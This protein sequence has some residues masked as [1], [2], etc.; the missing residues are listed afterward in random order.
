LSAAPAV[1]HKS[2]NAWRF[3]CP[4][5]QSALDA[6]GETRIVCAKCATVY[7]RKNGI[8]SLL[9]PERRQ[10]FSRFLAEYTH[11][12]IAEGRGSQPA[13]YYTRLPECD[14]SHPMAWQ[15]RIRRCTVKAFDRHVA[16]MLARGSKI[17]D[18]GAGYGWFSNHL[19]RLGY[20]P[21]AIDLSVDAEDGLGAARHYAPEWPLVQAEF[22]HLPFEPAS[23]DVVV[24]NASLHY[25]TDY[26]RTITEALRVLSSGGR[27]VVLE[28]PIYKRDESGRRMAAERHA[29]FE[30]RYGTRSESVPSIEYLTWDMLDGLGSELGLTWQIIRPWYGVKR[31]LRPWMARLRKRREPSRFAILVATRKEP[32]GR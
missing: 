11:V 5:C 28:S 13:S 23:L 25:S 1:L 16:P 2:A 29:H 14:D 24:Y 27:I 22:D 8:L 21:C 12:R 10:Y 7:E 18:V 3:A 32:S 15:W 9:S 20:S 6:S 26:A 4:L 17:A 30:R 31:A 19:S